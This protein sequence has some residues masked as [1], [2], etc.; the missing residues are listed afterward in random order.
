MLSNNS[1]EFFNYDDIIT[2]T[3]NPCDEGLA[4]FIDQN[5]LENFS[6]IQP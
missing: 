6:K 4:E 1:I 3:S 5:Q 2:L